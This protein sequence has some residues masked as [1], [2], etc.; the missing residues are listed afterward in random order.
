MI[1][2]LVRKKQRRQIK[3]NYVYE[4]ESFKPVAMVQ[5]DEIYYYH[6]DHLGTPRELTNEQGKIV[7]KAQYKT[8]GNVALK[9]VE[10]VENNL[11]FQGQYFDE[12][13]GLHYNRHRYYDPSVGQFT[14]QDPI[15][16]LGGVNNYQYAPNPTGWVDPS[17]LKCNEWNTFQSRSK[18]VF[19][20]STQAALGYSL[21]KA[22]CWSEL[23]ALLPA[24]AW[25]PNRG[26]VM[27]KLITLPIDHEIDRYGGWTDASGFHDAGTFVSPVGESFPSRALPASS[28]KKPFKKYKV[29]KPIEAESSPA[30]PWFGEAG[31]GTQYEL[32]AGIDELVAA[33][34]LQPI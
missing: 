4:P 20:N 21:W 3:K 2:K 1:F 28:L 19:S 6:L 11:R 9:N 5:D 15:G 12:E 23:E 8:Y 10:E 32:P 22:Q 33:G 26:A 18:G 31:M 7:W 29:L 16:L 24:G 25:P 34:Y 27:S 14:T 17:G 30:I 13:T